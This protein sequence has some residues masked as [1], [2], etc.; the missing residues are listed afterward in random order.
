MGL[1]RLCL[2]LL[3]SLL[4]GLGGVQELL[5]LEALGADLRGHLRLLPQAVLGIAHV[6]EGRL[7]VAALQELRLLPELPHGLRVA[8]G[9]VR[10][11]LGLHEALSHARE[12][13]EALVVLLA[14]QDAR[15]NHHHV[16]LLELQQQQQR[17]KQGRSMGVLVLMLYAPPPMSFWV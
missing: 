2:G 12:L 13:R 11:R 4:L 14:P 6:V 9:E 1:S 8:A 3:G 5:P 17:E 7:E 10:R 16:R 15:G